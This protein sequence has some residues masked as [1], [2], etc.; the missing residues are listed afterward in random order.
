[1]QGAVVISKEERDKTADFLLVKPVKRSQVVTSKIIASL[2]SLVILNAVTW[3]SSIFLV[4]I[5]NDG[6]SINALIRDLMLALMMLQLIFF[7][8][9][10]LVGTIVRKTKK[11]TGIATGILLGTFIMSVVVD[12][13]SKIKV[14]KYFTPFKYFDGKDIFLHGFDLNYLILSV[15][16]IV[17]SIILTYKIYQ[18]KDL[19]V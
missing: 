4:D 6:E 8:V 19:H 1:M 7:S 16:I 3:V 15:I 18:N 5:Y 11:A 12:M 10:L 14:L 17:V 9:G 13:Y 2:T